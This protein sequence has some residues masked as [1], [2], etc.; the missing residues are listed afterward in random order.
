MPTQRFKEQR[1]ALE[2]NQRA[3]VDLVAYTT[4]EWGAE[5]LA[6]TEETI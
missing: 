1:G 6:A 5:S 3:G 2:L 4:S